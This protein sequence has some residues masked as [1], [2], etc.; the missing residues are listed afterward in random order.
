M[1]LIV[2]MSGSAYMLI[3][4]LIDKTTQNYL[5]ESQKTVDIVSHSLTEWID[6]QKSLTLALAADRDVSLLF[7]NPTDMQR[8]DAVQQ[9]LQAFYDKTNYLENI[10]LIISLPE[11]KTV[12][13]RY[14]ER[15]IAIANGTILM[16]TVAGKTLGKA[17]IK[18]DFVY[19]AMIEG[20]TYISTPYPSI[21]RGNPIFVISTPVYGDNGQIVGIVATAPILDRFSK[22]FTSNIKLGENGYA[23]ICDKEGTIISHPDRNKMLKTNLFEKLGTQMADAGVHG[24]V[25]ADNAGEQV[26]YTFTREPSTG[27]Y[28]FGKV[29]QNDIFKAF[30]GE[31]YLILATVFTITFLLAF[32]GWWLIRR[33]VI[34]PL[35]RVRNALQR[36]SPTT[37]IESNDLDTPNSSEFRQIHDS[38]LRMSMIFHSYINAQKQLEDEIRHHAMY[39]QLTELPNRRF[40]Y[41]HIEEEL[42]KAANEQRRFALFFLDLDHFKL[43]NDSLGHDVGDK[44]LQETAK[45][46]R[47]QIKSQ[48]VLARLGGDEF[49]IV[50]TSEEEIEAFEALADRIV[51]VMHDKLIINNHE[52]HEFII[53][54]SVGISIYPDHG[55]DI[56]TLMKHADIALYE[57][58]EEGRNSYCLFDNGMNE[59]VRNQLYLEQDM[60]TALKEDQYTLYFQPQ[61]DAQTGQVI[62]A[63]ALIRWI[64]PEMGVISP[65]RFIHL[66]ENTGFIYQLGDWIIQEACSVLSRWQVNYPDFKLSINISARQFQEKD[67]IDKVRDTLEHYKIQPGNLVFEI[68]ETLIMTQKEQSMQVLTELKQM[69]LTIAMDDFGTGYSSLAYLK[70]FPIDIIK[71]D[72][73]FIQ[74]VFDNAD[75]FNI[76]K[77]IISLGSELGLQVIA[78][79]VES[80]HQLEFLQT[81][82]CHIIQGYFFS[83]PLP[84]PEL[85]SYMNWKPVQT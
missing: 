15:D 30:Q 33:E 2:V 39:D 84:E 80:M 82:H 83:M 18:R 20:K 14:R 73:A 9:R 75:D 7:Q 69:G 79:G 47:S 43:I 23:L 3:S 28:I 60:R 35:E 32:G 58:K 71:I 50:V 13:L 37:V 59:L 41:Q 11:D 38:L 27:W 42:I 68:T 12:T 55:S 36:F 62:G 26:W 56:K 74:G 10:G 77:A 53:S 8:Y 67:F 5:T 65:V 70:N 57:A 81:S 24:T 34:R 16:D 45:R 76:V 22:K 29:Y 72:K 25:T 44:L 4:N 63:E 46:L 19:H 1:L 40:L 64:H 52:T 31:I 85:I 54:T 61:V 78:E 51:K 6:E 48:D 17:S 21:L 66:A 49:I